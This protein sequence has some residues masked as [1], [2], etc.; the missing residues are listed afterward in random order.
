MKILKG[1]QMNKSYRAD[2]SKPNLSN[3]PKNDLKDGEPCDHPG[4]TNHITHPCEKCGRIQAGVKKPKLKLYVWTDFCPDY[5]GGLA[6]AIA[7]DELEAKRL[8][9]EKFG[10]EPWSWGE[11]SVRSLTKKTAQYVSGG[12]G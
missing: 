8:I 2:S 10:Y 6:F 7:S 4:C 1:R 12:G 5:S 9:V 11:L 3:V